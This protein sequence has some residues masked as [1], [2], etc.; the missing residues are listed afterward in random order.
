LIDVALVVHDFDRNNGQG[1]YCVELTKR[2]RD[3]CKFTLYSNTADPAALEGIAWRRV[4]AWRR[5]HLGVVFTFL[6]AAELRLASRHHDLVHAQGLSSWRAD[7]VTVHMIN[8][9]RLRR[10][11]SA[12][13]R[14]RWFSRL[15]TPLERG[16]Y[17][18]PRLRHALV[19]AKGLARE[20]TTEYGWNRPISVVPHGTDTEVFRPPRD[21]AERAELR[22][23]FQVPAQGWVWLF[24]GEAVKGLREV[25]EQLPFFPLAHLLVVTRSELASYRDLAARLDVAGRITFFGFA[26][27]PELAYRAADA[28]IYPSAYD[29]FGMVATEAMASGLPVVLGR[30]MGAAELVTP[31][32]D[33]LVCDPADGADLRAQIGL[34][35]ADATAASR[36]GDAARATIMRHDWSACAEA[37]WVA[38]QQAMETPRLF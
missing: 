37:T 7:I 6:V 5:R 12:R 38:Y 3:R 10:L 30:E 27:Q 28:F 22:A 31:G 19:M 8:A 1:R 11:P 23:R 20:L 25:I 21:V 18:R 32:G 15:V 2:L 36:L 33:G 34:L 13:R 26:P 17:R 29:P 16:F 24:M 4:P 14:D 35:A 9:A